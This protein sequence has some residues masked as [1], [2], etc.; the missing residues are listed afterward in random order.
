MKDIIEYID[1]HPDK[2]IVY[3]LMVAIVSLSFTVI[4][5]FR[6]KQKQ[7]EQNFNMLIRSLEALKDNAIEF[8]LSK[9]QLKE[10]KYQLKEVEDKIDTLMIKNG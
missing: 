1:A 10:V 7:E 4:Y 9:S 2:S 6:D 8:K 5:L 3:L